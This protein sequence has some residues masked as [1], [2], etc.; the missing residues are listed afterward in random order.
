MYLFFYSQ[1]AYERHRR[2]CH[3]R[4]TRCAGFS[5]FSDAFC[6]EILHSKTANFGWSRE[7]FGECRRNFGMQ[8]APSACK[9]FSKTAGVQS[10]ASKAFG[11]SLR[12]FLASC[13]RARPRNCAS[14]HFLNKDLIN[15]CID[16]CLG[17]SRP[18]LH[19]CLGGS[20]AILRR[21]VIR[22]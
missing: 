16:N 20:R 4:S 8:H 7:N 6:C 3:A 22:I 18:S 14:L 10:T 17:G 19:K 1:I 2:S 12:A 11:M 9:S 13:A 15:K 21:Y 5:E